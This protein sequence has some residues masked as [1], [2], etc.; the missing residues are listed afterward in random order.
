MSVVNI[1]VL[2][3]LCADN[4]WL[5]FPGLPILGFGGIVLL[6]TNIQV[7]SVVKVIRDYVRQVDHFGCCWSPTLGYG[8]RCWNW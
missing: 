3:I 7:R 1:C 2:R 6:I 5:L 8:V 4:P